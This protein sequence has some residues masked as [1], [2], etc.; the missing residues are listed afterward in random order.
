MNGG[1]RPVPDPSVNQMT[2]ELTERA[3][4]KQA[5]VAMRGQ[6]LQVDVNKAQLAVSLVN[7]F[8]SRDSNHSVSENVSE[9]AEAAAV[10]LRSF[11]KIVAPTDPLAE[12]PSEVLVQA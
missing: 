6:D 7:A 10:V 12:I 9:A 4:D 11:F 3:Q 8:M 2:R 1:L 5:A